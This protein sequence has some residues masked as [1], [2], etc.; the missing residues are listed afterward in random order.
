MG[1]N[2]YD[3]DLKEEVTKLQ[4][5]AVKC[6]NNQQYDEAEAIFRDILQVLQEVYHSSNHPDCVKTEKS[7]LMVQRRR[8]AAEKSRK[9]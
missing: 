8:N 1:E 3:E 6:Y 7:I 9:K 5:E 4:L 2:G